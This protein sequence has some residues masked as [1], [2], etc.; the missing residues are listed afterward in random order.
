LKAWL[1]PK[2]CLRGDVVSLLEHIRHFFLLPNKKKKKKKA[3]T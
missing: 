1:E 3:P 2:A